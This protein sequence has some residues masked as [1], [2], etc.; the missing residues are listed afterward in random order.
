MKLLSIKI[1]LNAKFQLK[2]WKD[3]AHSLANSF[4]DSNYFF[5]FESLRLILNI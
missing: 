1:S 5:S 2:D 4:K 3:F